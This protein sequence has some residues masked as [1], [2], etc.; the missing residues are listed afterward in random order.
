M[1]TIQGR[2]TQG[3]GDHQGHRDADLQL[4]LAGV[5][6]IQ[7]RTFLEPS[8]TGHTRPAAVRHNAYAQ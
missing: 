2:T 1:D 5:D 7:A 6:G 3:R 4:G 8:C